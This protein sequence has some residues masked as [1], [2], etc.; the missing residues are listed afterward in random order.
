MSSW[1]RSSR[2][3]S[4][5]LT[6][7][8]VF[9]GWKFL[10]AGWGKISNPDPFNATGFL[11]GAIG[12]AHGEHPSVQQWYAGFLENFVLPNVDIFNFLIPV[13]E[14]LV[15]IGLILGLF[16][17][18]SSLMA[19]LLNFSFLFAGT[20]SINPNLI[21][22]EF[23]LIFSGTNAGRFGIDH[24]LKPLISKTTSYISR[25]KKLSRT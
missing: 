9:V 16:T 12:K 14:L 23:I 7:L 6:L 18:F 24:Y 22:I 11:K 15:G 13:G 25:V 3:A 1:L 17:R 20:I 19:A 8:R 21:I 4:V 5:M 2:I 10:S